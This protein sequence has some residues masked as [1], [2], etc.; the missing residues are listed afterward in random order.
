MTAVLS[1]R[2]GAPLLAPP[3][4]D[5]RLDGSG[6]LARPRP[7][8]RRGCIRWRPRSPR[9]S[10]KRT[11]RG[12]AMDRALAV[13]TDH[14]KR[15]EGQGMAKRKA[16]IWVPKR[17][18]DQT[19]EHNWSFELEALGPIADI[20]EIEA[21]TRAEFIAGARDADAIMTSWGVRIDEEIIRALDKC[22]VIGVGSVGVDMVDVAA[23]TAAGI[24]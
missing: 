2:R 12:R 18:L 8:R 20:V 10:P 5:L 17:A 22:V 13:S 14:L 19:A 23:A 4:P 15:T 7:R 24:V 9:V 1:S 16:A 21:N 6:R 3:G 11:P